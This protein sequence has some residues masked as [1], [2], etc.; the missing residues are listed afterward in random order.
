MDTTWWAALVAV[1]VLALVATL[2]DG[3]GRGHRPRRRRVRAL[4]ARELTDRPRPGDIWWA[5]PVPCLVLAVRDGRA[6]V[7]RITGRP[8]KEPS[9]LIALPGGVLGEGPR[10]LDPGA[11]HELPVGALRHR[12]GEAD[13]A[14]WDRVRHL[15]G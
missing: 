6:M 11:L 8:G 10:Y 7:V 2:V 1:L 4:A 5:E 14:L 15:A 3:W 9:G 13:P 12:V